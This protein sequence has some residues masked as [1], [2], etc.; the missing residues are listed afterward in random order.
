[1]DQTSISQSNNTIVVS[2]R[3]ELLKSDYFK[4]RKMSRHGTAAGLPRQE[5]VHQLHPAQ[6]ERDR[7]AAPLASPAFPG[8][9]RGGSPA[10]RRPSSHRRWRRLGAGTGLP[11]GVATPRTARGATRRGRGGGKAAPGAQ[12][13]KYLAAE[14]KTPGGH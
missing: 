4:C 8:P 11:E 5:N 1:M 7:P 10:G 3:D 12:G 6:Q 14:L 2:G 13:D 9:A